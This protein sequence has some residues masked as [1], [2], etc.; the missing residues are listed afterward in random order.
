MGAC[1]H[2]DMYTTCRQVPAETRVMRDP[3]AGVIDSWKPPCRVDAE[4]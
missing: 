1:R 4:D 2:V 3:E